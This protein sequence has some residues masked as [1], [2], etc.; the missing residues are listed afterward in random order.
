LRAGLPEAPFSQLSLRPDR[1]PLSTASHVGLNAAARGN[2]HD[3][4]QS[5]DRADA[6]R[7]RGA[8]EADG[9]VAEIRKAGSRADAIATDLAA[10]D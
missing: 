1:R 5:P 8:K 2:L 9:V 6:V 4:A 7:D 10:A 3:P